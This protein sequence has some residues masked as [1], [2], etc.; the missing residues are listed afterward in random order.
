MIPSPFSELFSTTQSATLAPHSE[1]RIFYGEMP[2]E[3]VGFLSKLISNQYPGV[4]WS[5]YIDGELIEE[6]IESIV[7]DVYDPPYVVKRGLEVVARNDSE[8][9]ILLEVICDGDFYAIPEKVQ[10]PTL[11]QPLM[12]KPFPVVTQ[13]GKAV[14][15]I[16]TDIR[17][18]MKSQVP[19]GEITDEYLDITDAVYLLYD[20]K[21]EGNSLEWTSCGV[22]NRGPN[23]VFV[24][25]N[26]WK[27]PEAPIVPGESQ[28]FDLHRRGAIKRLYLICNSGETA[29]VK[30]HA[31][32]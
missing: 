24:A 20:E 11:V 22:A 23:D 4:V 13:E 3:H 17:D 28:N 14:K 1:G 30:I 19:L 21:N 25:V 6:N 7:G 5:W 29:R 16:L 27:V 26:E 31:L 9:E 12:L 15:K 32:K 10:S 2:A 18:E 8:M